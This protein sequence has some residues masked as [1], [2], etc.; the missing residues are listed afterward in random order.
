M[1]HVSWGDT[2]HPVTDVVKAE[3]GVVISSVK[4]NEPGIR[5][6]SSEG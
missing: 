2:I 1:E 4:R 6:P 3:L 5:K